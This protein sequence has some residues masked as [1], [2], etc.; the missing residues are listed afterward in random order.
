MPINS[1][2]VNDSSKKLLIPIKSYKLRRSA[3]VITKLTDRK[4]KW[5]TPINRYCQLNWAVLVAREDWEI[6]RDFELIF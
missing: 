3:D 5:L 4:K 1:Y 6:R 2:I